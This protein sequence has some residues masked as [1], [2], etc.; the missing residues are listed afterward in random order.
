M[1]ETR[2]D[3]ALFAARLRALP[4]KDRTLLTSEA[5]DDICAE[6]LATRIE[7]DAVALDNQRLRQRIKV[8]KPRRKAKR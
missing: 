8:R 4:G 7:A 3:R 2:R 5:I 6:L 1:S